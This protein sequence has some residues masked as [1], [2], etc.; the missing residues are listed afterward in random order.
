MSLP[1]DRQTKGVQKYS[2]AQ[3][4]AELWCILPVDKIAAKSTR[5]QKVTGQTDMWKIKGYYK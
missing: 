4:V 5:F 3:E 1:R 2:I